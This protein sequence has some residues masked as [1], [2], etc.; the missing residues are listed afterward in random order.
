[1][2]SNPEPGWVEERFRDLI[3]ATSDECG[4][5]RDVSRVFVR[6]LPKDNPYLPPNW[7][8]DLRITIKNKAWVD[9]YLGGSWDVSEGQLF[10]EFD[11]DVHLIQTPPDAYLRSLALYASIDHAS[12][13]VTCLVAAGQDPDGNLIVLGS[14]YERDRLVSEHSR[15]MKALLDYWVRKCG[16]EG[17]VAAMPRQEG[18]YQ[19]CLGYEYILIDPSTAA[20]TQQSQAELKSIQQLYQENGIPTVQAWNSIAPGLELLQE[21]IHIQPTHVHPLKSGATQPVFGSP[22]LFIVED[23]NR[24]GINE[25]IRFKRT[26]DEHNR[27]KYIGADHWLDNVRYIA[28]SRPEPPERSQSD[29]IAMD[30][31]T[32]HLTTT[33]DKW[34]ATFGK[35]T[36]TN[37]WWGREMLQ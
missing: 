6:A 34:A 7:E 5:A 16:R 18:T 37:Q 25:L 9:K 4:V 17:L 32:R 8:R 12:T 2:G 13:G 23:T 28:M 10:K 29:L 14:Y 21:Y 31:L 11:R 30:S 35:P 15:S 3:D 19:S 22:R 27:I 26:V 20:K 33:H 36:P 1:M 24:D